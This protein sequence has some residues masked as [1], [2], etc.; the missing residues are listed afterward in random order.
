MSQLLL[1]F[2]TAIPIQNINSYADDPTSRKLV[3]QTSGFIFSILGLTICI[4]TLVDNIYSIV[5][6]NNHIIL[7]FLL[8]FSYSLLTYF[9]YATIFIPE[10][11]AGRPD[12]IKYSPLGIGFIIRC[13][14]MIILKWI[15]ADEKE[16]EEI[17]QILGT[18]CGIFITYFMYMLEDESGSWCLFFKP[19]VYKDISALARNSFYVPCQ[20][21]V[22]IHVKKLIAP[23]NV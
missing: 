10:Y 11:V 17:E 5:A 2:K 18:V 8:L 15:G 13:G 7:R 20:D 23:F 4:F 22:Q 21:Q 6:I 12:F 9:Y 3:K 19:W 16:N 1:R 14:V